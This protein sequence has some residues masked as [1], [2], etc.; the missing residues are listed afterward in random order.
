MSRLKDRY[1]SFYNTSLFYFFYKDS[2]KYY[3]KVANFINFNKEYFI[4]KTN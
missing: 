1:P 2:S 4:P 3:K